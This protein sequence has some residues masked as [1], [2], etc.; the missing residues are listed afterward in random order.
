MIQIHRDVAS[1]QAYGCR[2]CLHTGSI[3][4]YFGRM[5]GG[6]GPR[7]ELFTPLH[8]FRWSKGFRDKPGTGAQ[9][10]TRTQLAAMNAAIER[11]EQAK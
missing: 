6:R 1:T 2:F 7:L 10:L 9:P 8:R 4:V 3:A 11:M 5:T